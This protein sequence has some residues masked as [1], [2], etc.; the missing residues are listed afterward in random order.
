MDIDAI[1]NSARITRPAVAAGVLA[2]LW[3]GEA[4]APMVA[5]R[6]G[7]AAHAARNLTLG[8]LNAVVL[9]VVFAGAMLAVGEWAQRESLGLLRIVTLPAWV[10]WTL[11]LVLID[12]W[13]YAWHVLNHKLP[14]LW[15]FHAVHHSDAQM[16]A[17]S[18]VRFHIGEV[19]LSGLAR[20][21]ILPTIGATVEHLAL[22]E[23]IVTPIV[24]FHH[25]NLRVPARLDRVLRL[26][27][28]TPGMHWVHHS[29]WRPETDSN[30]A[31]GL[32]LWDRLF[33]TFRLRDD[34]AAINLGLDGYDGPRSSTLTGMLASPARTTHPVGGSDSG[35]ANADT[36]RP[37]G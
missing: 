29:R 13:Q 1:F 30:F 27:I 33:R 14:L 26:L 22:Y 12:A 31:S 7:R 34:P 4:V 6:T 37:D 10:H 15:R 18:G 11:A 2:L 3:I 35:D 9:A 16:D 25:S 36:K 32:S 8:V 24:L 19:A 17:S 20:L 5:G 23:L 21:A 28:V